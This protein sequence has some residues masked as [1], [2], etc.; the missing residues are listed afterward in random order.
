MHMHEEERLFPL[1]QTSEKTEVRLGGLAHA[2]MHVVTAE[3]KASR[4]L[5]TRKP[6]RRDVQVLTSSVCCWKRLYVLRAR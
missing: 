4:A 6:R 5:F 1:H 2:C 3:F